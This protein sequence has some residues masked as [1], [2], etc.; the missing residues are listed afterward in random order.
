MRSLNVDTAHLREYD[1]SSA[2]GADEKLYPKLVQYPQETMPLMDS[3]A[4]ELVEEL[5]AQHELEVV[6]RVMC[7]PFNL[8]ASTAM[9]ELDPRHIDTLLSVH[10]MV[11]RTSTIIPDLR[12]AHFECSLC[13]AAVEVTIDHAQIDEPTQCTACTQKR[14]MAIV[15]NR[16]QFADKQ[17]VK[18][19][20]APDRIPEGETPQTITA[21]CWDDL[22]DVAKPGD[23]IVLTGVLRAQPLRLNPRQR[24][25]KAVYKTY[26]DVQHVRK[27]EAGRLSAEDA[28]AAADSEWF[29]SF[30]EAGADDEGARESRKKNALAI[31]R[32]SDAYEALALALAPSIWELDDVKKGILCQLFAGTSVSLAPSESGGARFRG[33]LNVLLVGD[34]GTSKSQLLQYVHKVAPRGVYTSGKGSSAVGLT[35]YVTKDPESGS[36]VLESGALV[37]SDRGVCCIDEFDKMSDGAR[38]VLHEAMEQ[39]TVSIAK[40]GIICTLNARTSILASANPRESR[41]NPGLSVIDNIDLPPTLLSRFDLIYLLLDKP[42]ERTDRLLA[43]HLVGLYAARPAAGSAPGSGGAVDV[44]EVGAPIDQRTLTE[45]ISYARQNC[46]PRLSDGAGEELVQAYV[47]M[48]RSGAS[49]KTIS[50]TPRQLES[51]IRLVRALLWIGEGWR[52]G[53]SGCR[54]CD[55]VTVAVAVAAATP[56]QALPTREPTRPTAHAQPPPRPALPTPLRPNPNP[57]VRAQAEAHARLHLRDVVS[58]EDVDEA[59]RLMRVATQQSATDPLTGTIDMDLIATGRSAAVSG[60]ATRAPRAT[61]RLSARS[62]RSASC[63]LRVR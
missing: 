7:R 63:L 6:T 45:Y 8:D 11:T 41:Y 46:H 42:A 32:R 30:D 21:S 28:R 14:C 39:Q 12:V 33:D 59:V 17:I 5:A 57:R 52:E 22:V 60:R 1:R 37:L 24:T 58:T 10:G 27:V 31:S 36:F 61:V 23:R 55:L 26:F 18:L 53:E 25:C 47:E 29:T 3:A 50:A 44:S 35:A 51:L 43:R 2:G 40:A 48:R 19:Q 20:E 34:P 54:H 49:R 4:Q 15:H 16:C 62:A 38:S 13:G 9:R 56:A